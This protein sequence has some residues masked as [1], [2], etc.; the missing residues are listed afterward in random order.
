MSTMAEVLW[1]WLD[2]T[3]VVILA[4]PPWATD[5]GEMVVD[6]TAN[7]PVPPEPVFEATVMVAAAA[8]EAYTMDESSL[9][10]A[11]LTVYVP[12]DD[13]PAHV[14]V[15]VMVCPA[16]IVSPPVA[17]SASFVPALS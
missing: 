15:Y 3:H 8:F 12:S 17:P 6:V 13:E 4:V 7:D 14:Q 1:L 9:R 11:T 16:V 10:T 5:V 2:R